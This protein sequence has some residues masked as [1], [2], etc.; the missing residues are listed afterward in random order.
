MND[1]NIYIILDVLSREYPY[2]YYLEMKTDRIR[3]DTDDIIFVFV[4]LV[5]FGSEYG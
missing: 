2:T 4:F 3:T 1:D 5:G